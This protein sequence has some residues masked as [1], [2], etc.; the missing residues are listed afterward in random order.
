M[1]LC[2]LTIQTSPSESQN[3]DQHGWIF[4]KARRGVMLDIKDS[5]RN[6]CF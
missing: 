3:V 2:H 1:Q 5:Y 6:T 4:E